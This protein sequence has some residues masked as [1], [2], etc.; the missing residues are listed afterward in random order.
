RGGRPAPSRALLRGADAGEGV[1][2]DVALNVA[3]MLLHQLLRLVA[4]ALG[5]GGGDLLMEAGVDRLALV[6]MGI[7]AQPAPADVALA[8]VE[9]IEDRQE[10]RVACRLGDGAVEAGVGL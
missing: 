6:A 1:L 7:L 4:L 10:Q 9:G 3:Q 5:D 2:V 8:R